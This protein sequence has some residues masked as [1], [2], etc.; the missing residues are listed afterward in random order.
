M[1]G[2]DPF[3]DAPII[4]VYTAE[5]AVQDGTLLHFNPVTALEAG[6]TLPVLL[7]RR[8]Y[9][10]A[11]EWTREGSWQ[12]E[13]ARFWDVLT[14]IRPAAKA[15]LR[16]PNTGYRTHV[17]RVPNKTPSGRPSTAATASRQPL[18][19]VVEGFNLTGQSCVI[20]SLPGED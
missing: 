15:A 14:V 11:V 6:Y 3:T 2:S 8:A 18:K 20:V 10:A 7:T 9:A 1:T 17:L 19:V 5:D 12:S 4:A 13:D 16:N